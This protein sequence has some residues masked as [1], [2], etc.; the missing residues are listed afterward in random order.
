[1]AFLFRPLAR[2]LLAVM[3]ATILAPGFGWDAAGGLHAHGTL[4]LAAEAEHPHETHAVA[5]E[6]AHHSAHQA[7]HHPAHHD[8]HAAHAPQAADAGHE[9]AA[10]QAF[11]SH[12]A[13]A[14]GAADCQDSLH[15]CCPGHVL[16]HLSGCLNGDLKLPLLTAIFAVDGMDARFSTR[17]PDGLERP[18]RPSAA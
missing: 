2:L 7:G 3:L 10:L 18:P 11:G 16:G 14:D 8:D 4:A 12:H 17:I 5:H 1:M 9:P 13:A 6:A 15:H